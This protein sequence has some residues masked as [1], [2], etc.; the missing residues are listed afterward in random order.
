MCGRG[1]V[2]AGEGV[3]GRGGVWGEVHNPHMSN[4]I[5]IRLELAVVLEV[6]MLGWAMSVNCL[7][8]NALFI[9]IALFCYRV[10]NIT[11]CSSFP[12]HSLV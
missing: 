9:T 8:G 6:M 10:D 11:T 12:Y 1:G 4:C 7:T 3:C 5:C 2:C